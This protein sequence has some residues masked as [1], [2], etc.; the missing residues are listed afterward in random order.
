RLRRGGKTKRKR[1]DSAI[2]GKGGGSSFFAFFLLLAAVALGDSTDVVSPTAFVGVPFSSSAIGRGPTTGNLI[3]GCNCSGAL[4]GFAGVP[5]A[6]SI[7]LRFSMG[8]ASS[9]W[10]FTNR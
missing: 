3:L 4:F 6:V 9:D 8:S 5:S 1:F 2:F 10:P 7:A